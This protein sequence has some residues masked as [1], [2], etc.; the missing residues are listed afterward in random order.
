MRFRAL[1]DHEYKNV[2]TMVRQYAALNHNVTFRCQYANLVDINTPG[3][4]DKIATIKQLYRL[5]NL[6]DECITLAA[7]NKL[8][9]YDAI[10]STANY[11]G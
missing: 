4:I 1:R 10:L 5:P 9:S 8:Y 2:R 6:Q 11:T 7:E 3:K